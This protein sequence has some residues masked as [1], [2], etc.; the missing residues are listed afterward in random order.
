MN[1]KDTSP[2]LGNDPEA[3]L[4]A[5][6][7]GTAKF[8]H[9]PPPICTVKGCGKECV[10]VE[11]AERVPTPYAC[12]RPARIAYLSRVCEDCALAIQEYEAQVA[13][14][15]RTKERRARRAAYWQEIWKGRENYHTTT[16]EQLPRPEAAKA[17]LEW[18]IEDGLGLLITGITGG[19]KT[20]TVYL[21]A[22]RLC[23]EEGH[24]IQF[25]NCIKLRQAISNA[26]RSDDHNARARFMRQ[27]LSGGVLILDDL[28]QMAST[29][30]S[31]EACLEII[32]DATAAG[33]RII[34][35]SQF[36]GEKFIA[37]FK[38]PETGQ[39][40]V[41]RLEETTRPIKF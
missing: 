32:E 20:R 18:R 16:L 40:I 10:G 19:G 21:L 7:G 11:I 1:L 5:A 29:P 30:S 34:A 24:K 17:V 33:V 22:K 4:L 35:T 6:T 9:E 15:A 27:L 14:A 37:A 2:S 23:L 39:A 3:M 41:R 8:D 36:T 38:K 12:A 13:E 31:E 26:A 28:G 25:W